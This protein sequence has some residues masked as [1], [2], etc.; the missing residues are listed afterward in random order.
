MIAENLKQVYNQELSFERLLLLYDFLNRL[1]NQFGVLLDKD[2]VLKSVEFDQITSLKS[3]TTMVLLN[4]SLAL[5]KY[6]FYPLYQKNSL[7]E[8]ITRISNSLMLLNLVDPTLCSRV[9][10]ET[11][12]AAVDTFFLYFVVTFMDSLED[13]K[14]GS[15]GANKQTGTYS[16]IQSPSRESL[17]DWWSFFL[18]SSRAIACLKFIEKSKEHSNSSS[19]RMSSLGR[20]PSRF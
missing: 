9:W 4:K 17:R 3:I 12:E 1:V 8:L 16:S 15:T 18:T 10:K 13:Y 11:A 20:L 5:V 7:D 14:D 6:H 19:A 2:T